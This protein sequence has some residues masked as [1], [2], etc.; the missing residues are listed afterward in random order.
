VHLS[1]HTTLLIVE[2]F[3][4]ATTKETKLHLAHTGSK[5]VDYAFVVVDAPST[6]L[7]DIIVNI[8]GNTICINKPNFVQESHA[9]QCLCIVTTVVEHVSFF[10]SSTMY[11]L[12]SV[13]NVDCVARNTF[14][15]TSLFLVIFLK[16]IR[17]NSPLCNRHSIEENKCAYVSNNWICNKEHY[18][19]SGIWLGTF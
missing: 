12:K 3:I 2:P 16:S 1:L 14:S 19:S 9:C 10:R 6:Y 5:R 7:H 8:V 17:G 13:I 15:F 18:N 11:V 4:N